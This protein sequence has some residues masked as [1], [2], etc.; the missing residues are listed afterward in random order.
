MASGGHKMCEV[1]CHCRVKV[2]RVRCEPDDYAVGLFL[3]KLGRNELERLAPL[4]AQKLH[5][6]LDEALKIMQSHRAGM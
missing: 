4:S 6:S 3:T 2:R 1:G 5:A